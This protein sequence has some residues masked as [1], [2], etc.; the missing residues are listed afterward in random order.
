MPLAAYVRDKS[1][2]VRGCPT[3]VTF[4]VYRTVKVISDGQRGQTVVA[5]RPMGLFL[6]DRNGPGWRRSR[7]GLL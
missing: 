2:F 4:D 1:S 6:A 7:G 3:L 5:A